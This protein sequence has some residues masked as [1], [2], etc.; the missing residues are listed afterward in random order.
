A[1]FIVGDKLAGAA[2]GSAWQPTQP[3]FTL[4][5]SMLMG[6][7]RATSGKVRTCIRILLMSTPTLATP[8]LP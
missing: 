8:Y 1:C 6:W 3:V 2:I 4:L 5:I 7:E